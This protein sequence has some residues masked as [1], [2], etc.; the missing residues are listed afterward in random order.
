MRQ[1]VAASTNCIPNPDSMQQP[2][3]LG[4][5]RKMIEDPQAG[6]MSSSRLKE[7]LRPQSTLTVKTTNFEATAF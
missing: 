4:S 5:L 1:S 3:R 6:I 2:L 7:A